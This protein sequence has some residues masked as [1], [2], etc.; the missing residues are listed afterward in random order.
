MLNVADPAHTDSIQG[1]LQTV[2]LAFQNVILGGKSM[3]H[4][5]SNLALNQHLQAVF[6]F[7]C[8]IF[9]KVLARLCSTYSSCTRFVWRRSRNAV[10]WSKRPP[11]TSG[12][13]TLSTIDLF[14]RTQV[15]AKPKAKNNTKRVRSMHDMRCACV[16]SSRHAK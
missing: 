5:W 3:I 1:Q 6:L 15:C 7:M 14:G 13:G 2:L 9:F 8:T 4:S 12:R 16:F 10:N 11:N